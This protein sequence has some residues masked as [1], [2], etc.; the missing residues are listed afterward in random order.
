LFYSR[1][2]SNPSRSVA[3]FTLSAL[4]FSLHRAI[5][6]AP[7]MFRR[8]AAAASIGLINSVNPSVFVGPLLMLS[9]QRT[10]R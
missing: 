4:L 3:L 6:G 2:G 5:L 9:G 8:T 7:S 10:R 1:Y